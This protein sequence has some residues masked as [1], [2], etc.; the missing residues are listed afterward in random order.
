MTSTVETPRDLERSGLYVRPA[1]AADA[2]GVAGLIHTAQDLA[3]VSPDETYPLTPETVR[4]WIEKRRAGYVLERR[5]QIVGYAELVDD[6]REHERVWVG[7]MMVSPNQ[8]GLGLGRTLVNALLDIAERDRDAR[9]VAISAFED[10]ERA[11][12]CY[13][14]CGFRD[15]TKHRVKQRNLVEMRYAVPGRR[16]VVPLVAA[17]AVVT[18]AA[19]LVLAIAGPAQW[20]PVVAIPVGTI[21]AL[22][23]WALSPLLPLRRDHGLR[24]V[25]R[26]L[27]YSGA[28]GAT[29]ILITAILGLALDLDFARAL[30]RIAAASALAAIGLVVLTRWTRGSERA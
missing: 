5:G 19:A 29:A 20:S 28:V 10:N 3:Q 7:H 24:R 9:E 21:S 13:R 30:T 22:G 16:P 12:R 2:S 26:S 14:G 25:L 27:A 23:A 17:L 18:L 15:Q 8:R 4:H 6:V 1:R 11:L